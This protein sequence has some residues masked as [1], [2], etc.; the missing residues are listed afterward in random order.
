MS[1]YK[2]DALGKLATYKAFLLRLAFFMVYGSNKVVDW[3]LYS[4]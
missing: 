4:I 2:I 3:F 1:E